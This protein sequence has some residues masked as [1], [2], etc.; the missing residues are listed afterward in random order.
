MIEINTS[1]PVETDQ[2]RHVVS[3]SSPIKLLKMNNIFYSI[4]MVALI[5][6]PLIGLSMFF[7]DVS[8][9]KIHG[10]NTWD[11]LFYFVVLPIPGVFLIRWLRLLVETIVDIAISSDRTEKQLNSF[12]TWTYSTYSEEND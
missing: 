11:W 6:S 1:T 3:K 10:R 5:M 4:S 2:W 9:T 8:F 12:V 7:A